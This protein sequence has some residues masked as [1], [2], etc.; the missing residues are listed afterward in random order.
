MGDGGFT[1]FMLPASE[2]RII[3][4]LI[5]ETVSDINSVP[6]C[7]RQYIHLVI[8]H[9]SSARLVPSL[10]RLCRW[11]KRH[12]KG[13]WL[14]LGYTGNTQRLSQASSPNCHEHFLDSEEPTNRGAA[15][16]VVKG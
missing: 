5:R 10:S 3:M 13:K 7:A 4:L 9:N 11:G 14:A 15:S 12:R 8:P 6:L 1:V 2:L 16:G